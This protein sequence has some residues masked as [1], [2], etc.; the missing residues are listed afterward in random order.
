MHKTKYDLLKHHKSIGRLILRL[1]HLVQHPFCNPNASFEA[2]GRV[3][4]V[5][6]PQT[7]PFFY[8][9][10]RKENALSDIQLS[11]LPIDVTSFCEITGTMVLL[12]IFHFSLIEIGI[13]G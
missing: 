2:V 5:P 3:N 10:W 9:F 12:I 1:E 11:L 7:I 6:K 8:F 13:T 4:M